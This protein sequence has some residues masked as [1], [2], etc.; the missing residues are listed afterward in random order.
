[1]YG[2]CTM[3]T[4]FP[5]KAGH[6][7]IHHDTRQTSNVQR[8]TH[9]SLRLIHSLRWNRSSVRLIITLLHCLGMKSQLYLKYQ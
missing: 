8:A 3:A 1:M 2:I 9:I 5:L 4:V 6:R 7:F